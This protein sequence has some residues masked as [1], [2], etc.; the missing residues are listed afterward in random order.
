[1]HHIHNVIIISSRN[2]EWYLSRTKHFKAYILIVCSL[3]FFPSIGQNNINNSANSVTYDI[4]SIIT[5]GN[6]HPL[7]SKDSQS[8]AK[9]N[10]SCRYGELRLIYIMLPIPT[11]ELFQACTPTAALLFYSHH[12]C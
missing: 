9:P 11:L 12:I 5:S 6:S 8:A 10:P 4:V 7:T 1:M 2:L 3:F